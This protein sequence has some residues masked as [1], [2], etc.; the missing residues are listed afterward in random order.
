M[1][2]SILKVFSTLFDL[3]AE[4]MKFNTLSWCVILIFTMS[5][6]KIT[7]HDNKKKNENIA[8]IDSITV[9]YEEVDELIK[10]E[11]YDELSRIYLIRKVALDQVIKEKSFY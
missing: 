1:T 6:S 5:C 3:Y 8:N 11:L 7:M 10:Q 2:K 9:T 4:N